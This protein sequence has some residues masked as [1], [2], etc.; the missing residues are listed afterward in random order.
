MPG[1]LLYSPVSRI[2]ESGRLA[3]ARKS[4][5]QACRLSLREIEEERLYVGVSFVG[6][7]RVG[8]NR[9][10]DDGRACGWYCGFLPDHA[11]VPWR[12]V[13]AS[14]DTREYGLFR[15]FKSHFALCVHFRDTGET[16]LV[17]DRCSQQPLFYHDSPGLVA[18]STTLTTFFR[19]LERKEF[20]KKWLT[21]F[22]FFNFPIGETTPLRNVLR[23]P[24]ASVLRTEGGGRPVIEGYAPAYAANVPT[25]P[26]REMKERA[27]EVFAQRIPRYYGS[28]SSGKYAASITSGFDS[29]VAVSF[30]PADVE[31]ELYT[32]GIAGCPDMQDGAEIAD[33]LG[34]AHH[35][36]EVDASVLGR[37]FGLA[38]KS[39]EYSGG[40]I[41]ALRATLTFAYERLAG[42][43]LQSVVTGISADHFFRSSGA[44]PHTFSVAAVNMVKDPAYRPVDSDL[45]VFFRDR[46]ASLDHFESSAQHLERFFSWS[47]RQLA[48]RQLTFANYE[49]A[50]K[51]FGGELALADNY[52]SMA[53]PYW[54]SDIRHLAYHSNLSTLTL[55][56]FIHA[57][58]PYWKRH[59]LFGHV[60]NRHDVF[61]RLP[62]HGLL[63]AHYAPGLRLPFLFHKSVRLGPGKLARMAGW[64]PR[65]EVPLENWP[66]WVREHI[67]D[68]FC[69]NAESLRIY[70]YMSADKVKAVLQEERAH[71]GNHYL[72]GKILT[73]ELVLSLIN[74]Y[75]ELP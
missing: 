64:N 51:Y 28:L 72:V 18:C 73:A 53:S 75:K 20:E 16:C 48:D 34:L 44:T 71:G 41:N 10:F 47:S 39:L 32:Y 55:T 46:D 67:L 23:M 37:L 66:S 49:L 36:L 30:R 38:G 7:C 50:A 74:G 33:A 9:I 59:S 25:C 2:D 61:R 15:E 5:D 8:G 60:L 17:S 62:V 13:I 42:F 11:T 31:L 29:R 19:S 21:D 14:L 58:F 45:L 69:R 22:V 56:P 6:R 63:P 52:V 24:A 54:D 40:T 68:D 27:Y 1:C 26:E 35:A 3:G 12:D 70:E 4:I 57:K 65:P 43:G